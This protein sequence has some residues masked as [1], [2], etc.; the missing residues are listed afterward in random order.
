MSGHSKWATT[1]RQKASTDARRSGLFTK[2]S[3]NITIAAREGADPN[4]N[5]KLRLAVD[6]AREASMP[7]DNIERAIVRGSG[8]LNGEGQLETMLYE[9]YG[10]EGVAVMVEA[11]SDNRN[12]THH[13][14]KHIFS[15]HG[16][17]LANNG[18]VAWMFAFRGLITLVAT[19][20]TPEQELA[21]IDLGVL[22]ILTDGQVHLITEAKDLQRV[23]EAVERLDLKVTDASVSYIP[24]DKTSI[25]NEAAMLA[26]LNA[27]DDDPDVNNVYTNATI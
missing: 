13:S 24:K 27:L 1:K 16:G 17:S 21:V 6:Q 8:G 26:F 23:K 20:L 9:G 11:V 5:F 18:A 4:F 19:S 12:R 3:K 7:K 14:V 2:L 10:P 22:D 15:D 25:K